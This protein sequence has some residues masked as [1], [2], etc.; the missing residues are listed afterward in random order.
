MSFVFAKK[1]HI[2]LPKTTLFLYSQEKGLRPEGFGSGLVKE[3]GFTRR[4]YPAETAEK[5]PKKKYRKKGLAR[6]GIHE[7]CIIGI[8]IL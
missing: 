6:Q 7:Y 2:F 1:Q 4:N 5:A 3:H 8:R